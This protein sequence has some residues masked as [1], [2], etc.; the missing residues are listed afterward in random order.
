MSE[1]RRGASTFIRNR[2]PRSDA[3]TTIVAAAG[4][5]IDTYRA[6]PAYRLLSSYDALSPRERAVVTDITDRM[7]KD[8][9]PGQTFEHLGVWADKHPE[10]FR[11][12]SELNTRGDREAVFIAVENP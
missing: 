4:D 7:T 1:K 6:N 3:R 2:Q 5:A 8:L 11:Q 9:G 10:A 12:F